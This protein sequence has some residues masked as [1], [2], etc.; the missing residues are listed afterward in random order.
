MYIIVIS[1]S[2]PA[3]INIRERLLEH[4]GWSMQ[5][6][7]SFDHHP[8]YSYAKNAVM[9]TI[10]KYHLF[11]DD[12]DTEVTSEL[13]NLDIMRAPKAVIF[14]SKHRSESGKRTLTVHPIG[15]YKAEAEYGGRPGE[16]VLATPHLMTIAY[17]KLYDNTLE[18]FGVKSD[19]SATFEVT[20]HGPYLK[21]PAFFIEIGSDDEAWVDK[22]AG[23][24]ISKT[25]IEIL[26]P[27]ILHQCQDYPVAIGVG[28][29]HYA[30]QH[31]EVARKKKISFGHMIPRYVIEGISE[32]VLLGAFNST[33]GA[34]YIYFH[35][36]S[37]K[38]SR[39]RELRD[40]YQGKGYQVV[41]SDDLEDLV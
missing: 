36:N 37:F 24:V 26:D 27:E 8:V 16:L 31:S 40:W 35:R 1:E 22:D 7:F 34:E 13:S 2:D 6:E 9:V 19:Y 15:N 25:I 11:F 18:H 3:G 41:R 12:L 38:K 32:K 10:N 23:R 20:H 17:R 21:T 33:V 29:G 14:A 4:P 39:Y 30:P 28:G 5:E